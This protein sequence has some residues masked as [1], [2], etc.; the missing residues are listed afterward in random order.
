MA[1]IDYYRTLGVSKEATQSDIKKAYRKLARQCHPDLHPDDPAAQA[2]FQELN[3]ANEVLGDPEKRKK[4]DEY[5]EHWKHA[6]EIEAARKQQAEAGYRQGGF[7]GFDN[8]GETFGHFHEY[9]G[10][11]S[12][13]SDFFEELFGWKSGARNA[14]LRGEDYQAQLQLPLR[15]AA[16]MH[17]Q[18]I[19]VNG[20]RLR[21]TIPAGI[22]DGQKIRLTG[23]GAPGLNGGANG[24]LYITF[25]ILPDP[26]FER[27]GDN[28]YST[29]HIDL[30]T[31]FLG[32][33]V[34]VNTLH[35]RVN[36][37][38]KPETLHGTKVRLKSKGFPIYK[39][40][41]AYGDLIVTFAVDLPTKLS[42]RQKELLREM[43]SG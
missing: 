13:F 22:A 30:Y 39:K 2:R 40:E 6:D 1:Y 5:G 14:P 24:D 23:R 25:H 31:A 7:Q 17:Q 32:G 11:A 26:D 9:R 28:L 21:I 41:G 27:R 3:E 19:E 43:K 8:N 38:V 12:G 10:N 20:Q 18:I 37:K 16:R 42:E 29:V 33:E 34:L 35:G 4:Y 15:E 36:L